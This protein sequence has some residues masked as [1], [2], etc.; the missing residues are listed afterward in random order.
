[1]NYV[2]STVQRLRRLG[3]RLTDGAAAP[4][5]GG[6]DEGDGGSQS[7][8]VSSTVKVAQAV[9]R[10]VTGRSIPR[11][12]QSTA[13][14]LVHYAFGALNGALY[15]ALAPVIPAVTLGRGLAFGAVLWATAD[16]AMLPL[17]GLSRVPT[18]YPVSTHA[19]SLAGHLVYGLAVDTVYHALRTAETFARPTATC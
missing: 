18:H 13:G 3:A 6:G 17:L 8:S 4:R 1:M 9:S 5:R 19:M 16:E 2:P 11:Q 10:T 7:D 15:G 14:N 12:E